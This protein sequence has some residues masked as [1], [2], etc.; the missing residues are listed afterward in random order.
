MSVAVQ[1]VNLAGFN[2]LGTDVMALKGIPNF[3]VLDPLPLTD[4]GY[5]LIIT[6]MALSPVS[7]LF[8]LLSC[9]V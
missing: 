1:L 5:I 4:G 6:T 7:V 9:T 8:N 2:K 3:V